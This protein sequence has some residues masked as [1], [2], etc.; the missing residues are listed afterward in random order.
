[1]P[2]WVLMSEPTTIVVVE[3]MELSIELKEAQYVVSHIIV[4]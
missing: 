3:L 1:M 2:I 4:L